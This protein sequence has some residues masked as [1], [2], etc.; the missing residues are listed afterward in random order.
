MND[1]ASARAIKQTPLRTALRDKQ[2]GRIGEMINGLGIN[3]VNGINR[4][5]DYTAMLTGSFPDNPYKDGTTAGKGHLLLELD[6]SVRGKMFTS[7]HV[8]VPYLQAGIGGSIYQSQ[9]GAFIP[10][11]L[12]M[13]VRFMPDAYVLVN[14]QYRIGITHRSSDH[15]F[16]S[17]GLAGSISKRK[18]PV[19]IKQTV[20]PAPV[21]VFIDYDADDDGV[22]DSTDACP[23]QKGL[24]ALQGCPDSDGDGIPDKDDDC[25]Y[26]TGTA[27]YRGCPV[28][29][30]DGDGVNDELDKCPTQKGLALLQG[31][32]DRD[33]DGIPD[34]EDRCPD[35]A[36]LAGNGGCPVVSMVTKERL[37][38]AAQQIRFATGSATLLPASFK[39]LNE[40]AALLQD[41]KLLH[42]TIEG[43]TDNIGIPSANQLLSEQRA[44]AVLTYINKKGVSVDRIVTRGYGQTQPIAT[45][46]TS[47]GR[48]LNRRVVL[49]VGYE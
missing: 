49:T 9:V 13:Q 3:Y 41:D 21:A 46:T 6:A 27:Q 37:S 5:F 48:Q 26:Q 45:N 20:P 12:G 43:H 1:F 44:Q 35:Q 31:C 23:Q 38:R 8:L 28:P 17:I 29:D 25:P 22:P 16:Y 30:T 40:V 24:A 14:A 42:L 47:T 34:A 19:K 10:A 15:F 7:D 36:G 2:F 33:G 4:H 18:A 32:P 11:G 39:A